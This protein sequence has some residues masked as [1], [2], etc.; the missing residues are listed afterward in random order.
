[1]S[2]TEICCSCRKP[3]LRRLV[4]WLPDAAGD[5]QPWCQS[6]KDEDRKY[7][8]VCKQ[9]NMAEYA[10]PRDYARERW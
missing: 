9:D 10:D 4:Q 8:Q 6:C 5:E 7:Q 3:I 1:M 2:G